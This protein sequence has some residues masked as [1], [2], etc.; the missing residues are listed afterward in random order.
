MKVIIID[1]EDSF[2][3]NL[4]ELIRSCNGIKPEVI[5]SKK[6]KLKQLKDFQK[7]IFSPGP[8]LPEDFPVMSQILDIYAEQKSILGICLGHQAICQYYGVGLQN[9]EKV[10]H[11]QA[12]NFLNQN[13]SKLFSNLPKE[14]IVGLYHS[15][16]VE[17]DFI[18]NE[19]K[20]TGRSENGVIMS[21]Q[22]K[23]LSIYG[24][25][26]H[27]ESFI[28]EFGQEMMQNFLHS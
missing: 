10:V 22:H 23:K 14:F 25:Q 16:I 4:S 21:V 28:T 15:W 27:P 9:L 2:T 13:N 11:G 19:L 17:D 24:V 8:G 18:G 20:I 5:N 12:R 3:F 7:I 26:F 6:V 1:N